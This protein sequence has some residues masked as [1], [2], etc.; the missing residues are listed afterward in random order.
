MAAA[1]EEAR[2]MALVAEKERRNTEEAIGRAEMT[3][4]CR[5][6]VRDECVLGKEH[7]TLSIEVF[8]NL[9]RYV[10]RHHPELAFQK[11]VRSPEFSKKFVFHIYVP[12]Q[13]WWNTEIGIHF[14]VDP[15]SF[16]KGIALKKNLTRHAD[17]DRLN[18]LTKEMEARLTQVYYAP[19]MPGYYAGERSFH[20]VATQTSL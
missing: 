7:M 20:E 2:A 16:T 5:A 15:V 17:I 11:K 1:S 4:I 8:E 12:P 19:G 6:F 3:D 14:E 9:V 18:A 10:R 13:L